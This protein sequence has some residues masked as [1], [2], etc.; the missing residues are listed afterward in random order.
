MQG[1]PID[2]A[3]AQSRRAMF[4][5]GTG[6][7]F[8]APVMFMRGSEAPTFGFDSEASKKAVTEQ[9]LDGSRACAKVEWV[10]D[11]PASQDT[12]G[13]AE[14]A[15][16][17]S[18]RLQRIRAHEPG[19]S[20]LVHVDG[21]WG[22]GKSTLLQFIGKD[23]TTQMARSELRRLAPVAGRPSLVVLAHVAAS[24]ARCCAAC[25]QTTKPLARRD[26]RAAPPGRRSVHARPRCP[27]ARRGRALFPLPSVGAGFQLSVDVIRSISAVL[28]VIGT[29]WGGAVLASKFLLWN[30]PA[31]RAHTSVITRI[32]WRIWRTTSGG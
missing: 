20:F 30:S 24:G 1:F 15:R 10:S 17:L 16:A 12:L 32:P 21:P 29:L 7:G 4:A 2:A 11:S 18:R 25:V 27:R 5:S 3:L 6:L 19:T 22:S 23:L 14:L 31:A 9:D 26:G 28:A 13:R 8:A